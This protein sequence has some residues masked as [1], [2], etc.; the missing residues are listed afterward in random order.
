M[1]DRSSRVFL[2]C[3]HG[4]TVAPRTPR[5]VCSCVQVRPLTF[6]L[7]LFLIPSDSVGSLLVMVG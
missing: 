6:A 4:I 2:L 3:V 1:L 7:L 5:K